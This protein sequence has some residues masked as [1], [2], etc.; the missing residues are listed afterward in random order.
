MRQ[1]QITIFDVYQDGTVRCALHHPKLAHEFQLMMLDGVTYKIIHPVLMSD[2]CYIVGSFDD[3][4][5][6]LVAFLSGH[7]Q[8]PLS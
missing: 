2:D 1:Y 6:E 5:Y 7:I 3:C 8:E 4:L